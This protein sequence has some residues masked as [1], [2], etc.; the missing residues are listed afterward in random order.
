MTPAARQQAPPTPS[1]RLLPS[2]AVPCRRRLRCLYPA[3]SSSGEA[4]R[5]DHLTL[6][7]GDEIM[8]EHC[9][10]FS[11]LELQGELEVR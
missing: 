4:G 9:P 7:A 10:L 5:A 1:C 3:S 8:L 11:V 6:R 2:V